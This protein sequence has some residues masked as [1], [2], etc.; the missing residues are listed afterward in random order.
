MNMKRIK[1]RKLPVWVKMVNISLEAWSVDGLSALASS[2]GVPI[3]MD[4]MTAT[5]CHKGMGNLGY[6]RVLVEVSAEKCLKESIEIQ[7]R[8]K[9]NNVKGT[10]SVKV[11]YD[12]KPPVCA[13]CRVFG[14]DIKKQRMVLKIHT[15]DIR[16]KNIG[17]NKRRMEVI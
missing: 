5:I 9:D 4:S 6:A 12:W 15:W 13:H 2:V 8:D 1:P 7:Y 10:K 17:K 11:V 14:H 16:G 3:L